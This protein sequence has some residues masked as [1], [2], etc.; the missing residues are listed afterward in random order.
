MI[1]KVSQLILLIVL[2]TV[3]AYADE[4]VITF[5]SGPPVSGMRVESYTE[6]GFTFC[7]NF[8]LFQNPDTGNFSIES[9]SFHISN[10][11]S[12][13]I[14]MG[15][16]QFDFLGVERLFGIGRD[17]FRGSNGAIVD[18]D[19][20]AGADFSVFRGITSLEWEHFGSGGEPGPAPVVMDNFRFNTYPDTVP[21]PEPA[22]LILLGSGLLGVLKAAKRKRAGRVASEMGS[23]QD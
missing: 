9:N 10:P 3:P 19:D 1:S 13:F 15:G 5:D 21:V 7:C 22:T 20:P 18:F 6:D 2:I 12:I 4:V 8:Q 23:Y 14:N 11:R 17:I 16:G